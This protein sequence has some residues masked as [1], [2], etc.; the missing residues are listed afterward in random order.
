MKSLLYANTPVFILW[1]CE[2]HCKSKGWSS[3]F[4]YHPSGKENSIGAYSVANET[5]A[6]LAPLLPVQPRSAVTIADAARATAFTQ[7]GTP[8]SRPPRWEF[9]LTFVPNSVSRSIGLYPPFARQAY[10]SAGP[11]RRLIPRFSPNSIFRSTSLIIP[12][13]AEPAS[14]CWSPLTIASFPACGPRFGQIPPLP[15]LRDLGI[16]VPRHHASAKKNPRPHAI[17]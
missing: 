13:W 2:K 7:F 17:A 16:H 8:V 5:R 1:N 10:G 15:T 3:G 14:L 9:T 6:E 12:A 11:A 4:T